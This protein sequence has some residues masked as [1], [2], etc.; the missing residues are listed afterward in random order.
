MALWFEVIEDMIKLIDRQKE[1]GVDI[2]NLCTN[3][4]KYGSKKKK[5]K[6]INAY[7]TMQ[8]KNELEEFR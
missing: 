4:S 1:I 7:F 3:A 8:R 6:F 5:K 2:K